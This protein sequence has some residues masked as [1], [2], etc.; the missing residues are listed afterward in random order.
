[1]EDGSELPLHSQG[2]SIEE[3]WNKIDG[4]PIRQI[5]AI[6]IGLGNVSIFYHENLFICRNYIYKY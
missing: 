4:S 6:V 3:E 5:T 1:M 2:L